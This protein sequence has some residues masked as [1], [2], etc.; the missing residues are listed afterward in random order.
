MGRHVRINYYGYEYQIS[1]DGA[2]NKDG[3]YPAMWEPDDWGLQFANYREDERGRLLYL[4][5]S[6]C[7][8]SKSLALDIDWMRAHPR[9]QL[10]EVYDRVDL[11]KEYPAAEY[12]T[13][14]TLHNVTLL[15]ALE[16]LLEIYRRPK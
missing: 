7:F 15:E 10:A 14:K 16:A 9:P 13:V 5:Q 11:R 1:V 4:C 6:L 2:K 3:L 8:G 12:T